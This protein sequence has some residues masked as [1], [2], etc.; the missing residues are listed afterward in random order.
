MMENINHIGIVVKDLEKAVR[1]HENLGLSVSGTERLEHLQVEV[2][3]IEIGGVR[4]ELISPLSE[5]HEL[6]DHMKKHGEGLHHIAFQVKDINETIKK[7]ENMGIGLAQGKPRGK[8]HEGKEIAFLNP[9][10]TCGI[11]IEVCEEKKWT[12]PYQ[13]PM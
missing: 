3:F 7:L 10:D 11:L 9:E 4:I 12:P 8:G 2:A 13:Q 1:L 6:M 5:D